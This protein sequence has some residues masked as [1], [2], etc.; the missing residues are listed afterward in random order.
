[1]ILILVLSIVM[2]GM[3]LFPFFMARTTMENSEKFSLI[4]RSDNK[5][6]PRYFANAFNTMMRRALES[7][8]GSGRI[9]LSKKER[10]LDAVQLEQMPAEEPCEMLVAAKDDFC[11]VGKRSFEKEIYCARSAVLPEGTCLR[12]IACGKRLTLGDGCTVY[13]WADGAESMMVGKGCDLGISASSDTLLV[14]DTQT[15]FHRLYA[16]EIRIG[17]EPVRPP[18]P[19]CP[20]TIHAQMEHTISE[21]E[22]GELVERTIIAR[23]DLR[24]GEDAQILGSIKGHHRVH[25]CRGARI[26]GNLIAND[27]IVLEDDVYVGGI[28]F[29]QENLFIGPGSQIGREG[30]IKSAIAK[31]SVYLAEQ[32]RIYGYVG[33]EKTGETLADEEYRIRIADEF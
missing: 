3:V 11:P 29:S 2:L 19:P 31:T 30:R 8:D 25:V 33:C 12:A 32:V 28:L 14:V 17:N 27:T 26:A 24:I 18:L 22:P 15:A 7:Y 5:R 13:R 10:L 4:V 21:V 6:D 16:A 23:D 20:D 1:M 9:Q